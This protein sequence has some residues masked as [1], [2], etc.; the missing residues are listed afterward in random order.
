[1]K[2]ERLFCAVLGHRY[3]VVRVLN[4]GARKVGCTRCKEAWGMHDS[5]RSFVPWDSELE[6]FYAPGWPLPK[7]WETDER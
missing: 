7:L 4:P 2:I 5:T 6:A 3:V 1:M